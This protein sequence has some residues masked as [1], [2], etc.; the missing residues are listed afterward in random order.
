M[1]DHQ[2]LADYARTGSEAAFAQLVKRHLGLVHAAARRQVPDDA[3]AAD[4]VQAVFL[5]LARKAGTFG[6]KSVLAGWLFRTTRF[7]ATRALRAEVRRQRREQ[8]AVAMQELHAPDPHWNRL[9]PELDE[10]LAGLAEADRNALLLRFAEGRNHREVGVALGLTEEAAKKRVNRA[11]EKLRWALAGKGVTLTVA[12]LAGLLTDRLSAAPP[13]GLAASIAHGVVTEIAPA[14]M[15]AALVQQTVAAWRWAKVKFAAACVGTAALVGMLLW[16]LPPSSDRPDS[17]E[18]AVAVTTEATAPV[19]PPAAHRAA[20]SPRLNGPETFRLQVVAADTGQP[21]PGAKVLLNV[22]ANGEWIAPADRATDADG[23]C[24]VALPRGALMRLDA[25]AHFPG[26][27]NRF[28]TWRSDWQHPRP[29]GY[30][31]RLGRAETVGGQVVDEGRKPIAGVSVWLTYHLSDTS[32]REPDEDRERLGFMRRIQLGVTDAQGRW[33]CATIPPARERFAFEFEHPDYVKEES[34]SVSRDDET[35]VG[36]ETLTLLRSRKM[37]TTMRTG[38]VAFGQIINS[39]DEPIPG[40]RI[41]ATWHEV[42]ATTDAAGQ[43]AVRSLPRGE[44]TF[45]ATADGY[46]AKQFSVQAGG[47]AV[48]VRLEAGAVLRARIVSTNGEPIAGATLL[49]D[50]GFGF[51][52]L[53]WDATTDDTGRVEWRS[54]PPGQSAF[55]FTAHAPG[56]RFLRGVALAADGHEHTVTLH[57]KLE[58]VG[59]VVDAQNGQPVARFKAIPGEGQEYP[60]FD[61]SELHYGA[62]GQYRL[63]FD[64][65]GAPV[66]RLEAEGYE[67]EIGFPQPG[68][69]GEPRCDF[70]L[71]RLDPDGGVRGVVLNP[72]GSPSAGAEVALCTLEKSALLGRGRFLRRDDGIVTNTDAAGRFRFPVVRQPHTVAAVSASGFARALTPSRGT[73]ELRLQPFGRITGTVRRDGQPQGGREVIL[74]DPAFLLQAG[75]IAP[76]VAAFR[77]TTDSS[78][79]F[80]ISQVPAGEFLL[81]LNPGSGRFLT[82]ETPVSVSPGELAN[83]EIGKPDPAGRIVIGRLKLTERLPVGEWSNWQEN[84]TARSLTRSQPLPE[85]PATLTAEDRRLWWFRW[86]E[87]EAGQEYLRHHRTYTVEVTPEG[88]FRTAGVLPGEYQLHFAAAPVPLAW[89]DPLAHR[90]AAWHGRLKRTVTVPKADLGSPE[91]IFELGEVELKIQQRTSK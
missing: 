10:A 72:D 73:V 75:C 9:A 70:K 35:A 32:W 89:Q 52:A 40:A 50:E 16:G 85:P 17:T 49:L 39:A 43:F 5:L 76:D 59:D 6:P 57:P 56:H 26:F 87:S 80:E 63:S 79:R 81:S 51:G 62:N 29:E 74:Q 91:A 71:R 82:D 1:E 38:A 67:T 30:T 21:L 78:G 44:A 69:A 48:R 12:L 4:V 41:G 14:G 55:N 3:L 77:A 18:P 28:F 84:L 19:A 86:I 53:G 8:E 66:V 7:V 2:L 11:L 36:R 27:E 33:L 24:V 45:T 65:M 25:G 64:E 42:A 13:A 23:F 61:R 46:S 20:N 83:V 90:A 31:L 68:P 22:V 54:A 47:E 60:N 34:L 15:A 88:T 37:V 58:V